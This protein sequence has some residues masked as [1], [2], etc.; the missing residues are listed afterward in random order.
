MTTF[1][2]MIAGATDSDDDGGETGV[3]EEGEDSGCRLRLVVTSGLFLWSR[4][5]PPQVQNL[6]PLNLE[7]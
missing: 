6:L 7:R 1:G 2:Y 3:S 4:S 5:Q